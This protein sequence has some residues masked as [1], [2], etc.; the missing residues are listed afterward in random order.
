MTCTGQRFVHL[1]TCLATSLTACNLTGAQ[2]NFIISTDPSIW[3]WEASADQ[4]VTWHSG[5]MDVDSS[6]SSVHVRAVSTFPGPSNTYF[7]ATSLDATV[8]GAPGIGEADTISRSSISRG[9]I[10]NNLVELA[11]TRF[12]SVLKI[13]DE[14]DLLPPGIG[15]RWANV[16]QAAPFRSPPPVLG[17]PIICFAYELALD[18]TQGQRIVSAQFPIDREYGLNSPI[19]HLFRANDFNE[20]WNIYVHPLVQQNLVLNVVPSPCSLMLLALSVVSMRNRTGSA[21]VTNSPPTAPST[22][23]QS[24]SHHR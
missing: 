16:S 12:G 19:V 14:S 17:N 4:G 6:V 1:F 21:A 7:G 11:V 2:N 15:T 18:G 9:Q 23:P 24:Q 20:I 10:T 8:T 3:R 22:P 13:D 5:L